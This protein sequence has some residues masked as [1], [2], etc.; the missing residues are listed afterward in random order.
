MEALTILRLLLPIT[1]ISYSIY[2]MWQS[3]N[4]LKA[5]KVRMEQIKTD[6]DKRMKQ[7]DD[8]WKKSWVPDT[9]VSEQIQLDNGTDKLKRILRNT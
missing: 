6:H 5:H 4:R 9:D 3:N 2:S 1:V 8:D 7:F